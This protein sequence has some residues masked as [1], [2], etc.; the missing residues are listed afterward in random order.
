MLKIPRI[1]IV[2][3]CKVIIKS[4]KS[5]LKNKN[6]FK[7]FVNIEDSHFSSEVFNK[8]LWRETKQKHRIT[9]VSTHCRVSPEGSSEL[10]IL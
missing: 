1:K 2:Q 8:F 9:R 7:Y 5:F 6:L 10:G 4:I 3:G